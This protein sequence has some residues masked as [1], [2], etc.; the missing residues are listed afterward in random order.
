MMSIFLFLAVLFPISDQNAIDGFW[1]SS[2]KEVKIQIF[3][4]TNQLYYG[5]VIWFLENPAHG[6][7]PQDLKNPNP[8]LRQRKILDIEILQDFHFDTRT[9]QWKNGTIYHPQQGKTYKGL[10]WIEG[11]KLFIRGYWGLLYRTNQWTKVSE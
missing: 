1:L 8:A 9:C 3:K 4:K 10:L 11:G 5:K 7:Y 6:K 2:D